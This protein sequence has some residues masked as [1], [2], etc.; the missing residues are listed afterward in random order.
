MKVAAIELRCVVEKPLGAATRNRPVDSWRRQRMLPITS[1]RPL[2]NACDAQYSLL[3]ASV[4]AIRRVLRITSCVSISASRRLRYS[5]TSDFDMLRHSAAA[6][7]LP[8]STIAMK[9]RR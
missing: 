7:K 3:P 8:F 5:L 4:G 2:T 9:T 6:V 1:Y